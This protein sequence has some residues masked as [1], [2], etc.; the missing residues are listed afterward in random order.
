[1]SLARII[2][3][4]IAGLLAAISL[5][6]QINAGNTID[7]KAEEPAYMAIAKSLQPPTIDI[8]AYRGEN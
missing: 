4:A 6:A 1:M 7:H 8:S 5:A 2:R 3:F